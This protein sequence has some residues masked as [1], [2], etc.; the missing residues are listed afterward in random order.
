MKPVQILLL[1]A[2]LAGRTATAQTTNFYSQTVNT[3][4]LDENPN[5]L[6]SVIQVS[7]VNGPIQSFNVT[8]DIT[9]GFNGDLYAYLVSPTGAFIVLFNRTGI[10]GNDFFGYDDT[11]FNLTFS[12]TAVNNIHNYR[13]LSYT[14]NGSGQLTGTW[15]ADG[16]NIDPQSSPSLFDTTSPSTPLSSIIGTNPNGDWTLFVADLSGGY[17]STWHDWSLGLVSAVPEPSTGQLGLLAG[18]FGWVIFHWHQRTKSSAN[19]APSSAP[20]AATSSPHGPGSA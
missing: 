18:L 11:G 3:L 10:G 19:A 6:N 1:L 17:Q 20:L 16:C 2:L 5:G 9:G 12:S 8:L 13:N 7:G 4:I 15:A 14:L